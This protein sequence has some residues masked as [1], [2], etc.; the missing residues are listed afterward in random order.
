MKRTLLL[1]VVGLLVVLSASAQTASPQ[2]DAA[3]KSKTA[4]SAGQA[5]AQAQADSKTQ[6][7]QAANASKDHAGKKEAGVQ[8]AG[9]GS[10]SASAQAGQNAVNLS[11]DT[12]IEAAL[13]SAVD[14][15][16]N[17][18]G[19]RVVAR[20][21][22]AVKSG[23]QVAIPKGAQVVGHVTQAQ[24]RSKSQSQSALGIAFDHCVLKNGQEVPVHVAIQ[25]VAAAQSVAA[26]S[27]GESDVTSAGSAAGSGRASGSGPVGGVGSTAG[28]AVGTVNNAAGNAGSAAG[29]VV[30]TTAR[31]A[32]GA[33]GSVAGSNVAGALNSSSHGVI[34]LQGLSLNSAASN[35]SQG[36]VIVSSTKNV[37]L[38]SG[39][40]VLL[41]AQGQH[42]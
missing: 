2:A 20:T 4:V 14:V 8:A 10:A 15:R 41:R 32:G 27:L 17:K 18:E 3:A 24:A 19:D 37:R 39:T 29:G 33:T 21:T 12:V 40:R 30:N 22:K 31:T 38:E 36:S 42:Q 13:E 26:S 5:G 28:A 7:S 6:A 16:K 23:D 1:A 34:G 11:S 35:A 25:A 9:S